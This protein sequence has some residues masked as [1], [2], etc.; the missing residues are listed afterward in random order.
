MLLLHGDQILWDQCVALDIYK[1][2]C[3]SVP[4]TLTTVKEDLN[5]EQT[6][7]ESSEA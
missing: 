2:W 3:K 7:A 1:S 5:G 6:L 4:Q